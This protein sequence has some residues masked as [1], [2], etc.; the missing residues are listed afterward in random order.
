MLAPL[1]EGRLHCLHEARTKFDASCRFSSKTC[2]A[3]HHLLY[4]GEQCPNRVEI[5]AILK[6]MKLKGLIK[7]PLLSNKCIQIKFSN[8][9]WVAEDR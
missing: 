9:I 7:D 5:R 1:V 4:Q 3:Y 2:D 6:K 8:L